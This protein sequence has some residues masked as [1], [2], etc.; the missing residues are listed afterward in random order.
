MSLRT[1]SLIV[2]GVLTF[3]LLVALFAATELVV[4]AGF[5]TLETQEAHHN[6]QRIMSALDDEVATLDATAQDWATWDDTYGF[7]EDGNEAFASSTL[8]DGSFVNNRLNVML[9]VHSSGRLVFSKAYDLENRRETPVPPSLLAHIAPGSLLLDH[10]MHSRMAG[11]LSLPEGTLLVSSHPILTSE[12]F[13]PPRGSLVFGRYLDSN[14][15]ERLAKATLYSLQTYPRNSPDLPAYVR[16]ALASLSGEDSVTVEPLDA[17]SIAGVVALKDMY[18]DPALVLV[19][20]FP[21]DIYKQGRTTVILVFIFS[22]LIIMSLSI[23]TLVLTKK[24]VLSRLL[25]LGH[26]VTQIGKNNDLTARVPEE[27]KDELSRLGHEVN[28]MLESLE[29]SRREQEQAQAELREANARLSDALAR[30]ERTPL[31]IHQERM[32]ALGQMASGIAHDISNTLIPIVGLSE[33]LL[34]R[35]GILEQQDVVAKYAKSINTAAQDAT[36]IVERLR[37]FY[38][39][40]LDADEMGPVNLNE[41]VKQTVVLTETRWRSQREAQIA[42]ATELGNIP[43]VKGS[44]SE[45]REAL[46]NLILN[47]VDAMPGGG[48]ITLRTGA[49]DGHVHVQVADTGVGMTEE[50]RRRCLEPFFTTKGER[51]TGMGLAMVYGVVKRHDGEIDIQSE[52]G[53]GTTFTLTLAAVKNQGPA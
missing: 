26:V 6:M 37:E 52:V 45:L 35:P 4:K 19:G 18:G 43:A 10:E 48:T 1:K 20:E 27:G 34:T 16:E 8:A 25:R 46:T 30:L 29:R 31:L 5:R 9:F 51:G 36:A 38:R 15:T 11:F 32:N 49:E 40:G 24:L 2:V 50:V 23:A 22:G 39:P 33:L 7:V 17:S 12:G 28:N 41:V 21:R 13:G 14:E 47:A 3:S 53:K 42:V 44:E